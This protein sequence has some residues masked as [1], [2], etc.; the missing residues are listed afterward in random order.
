[1]SNTD[2]RVA[3]TLLPV[4]TADRFAPFTF[5]E[6]PAIGGSQ[7]PSAEVFR[8]IREILEL[9]RAHPI[10]IS[11]VLSIQPATTPTAKR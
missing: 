10:R 11:T 6:C 7:K 5:T 2:Q 8:R 3:E 4:F 1:M 9:G